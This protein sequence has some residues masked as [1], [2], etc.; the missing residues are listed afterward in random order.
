MR[1]IRERVPLGHALEGVAAGRARACDSLFDAIG[2]QVYAVASVVTGHRELA[3]G[4][5]EEV[6]R[7]ITD[8]ASTLCCDPD[9]AMR[10]LSLTQRLAR[11]R[12]RRR[13]LLA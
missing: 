8:T 3:D 13:P 12:V 6:F 1:G 5:V 11:D 10:I 7:E 2:P 4:V 9:A